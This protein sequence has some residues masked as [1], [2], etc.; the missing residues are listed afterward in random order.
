MSIDYGS[1]RIGIAFSD[2]LHLLAYP[3][4]TI[5]NDKHA[6]STIAKLVKSKN[7]DKIVV[8]IPK[9]DK[10]TP[11]IEE[12]QQFVEKLKTVVDVKIEFVN[13]FYS[14]KIAIERLLSA[15]KKLKKFKP[16]LDSYAAC[17]ILQD[18]LDK[19]RELRND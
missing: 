5:K 7:V 8:G 6:L 13:E 15:G 19:Q 12:I 16:K 9:W 17:V 1:K 10:P 14:S 3:F 2:E 4:C 18:Y 11:V